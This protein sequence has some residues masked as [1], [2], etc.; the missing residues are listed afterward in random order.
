MASR[1]LKQLVE[2]G[3]EIVDAHARVD[4]PA[5]RSG[6]GK[7]RHI[8]HGVLSHAHDVTAFALCEQPCMAPCHGDSLLHGGRARL[9]RTCQ[10]RAGLGEY[11]GIALGGTRDHDGVATGFARDGHSIG[12]A[13]DVAVA[14]HRHIHRLLDARDDAPI[15]APAIQLLGIAAVHRDRGSSGIL[16]ADR[17]LRSRFAP[18]GPTAAE[19][20]GN[21]MFN[22]PANRC[23]D[24]SGQVRVAH[25]RAAVAFRDNLARGATHVDVDIGKILAHDLLDP[26][27]L[28]S[29]DIGLVAEQLHGHHVLPLRQIEQMTRFLIGIR[30][31]FSGNH[32]SI[33]QIGALLAA[34]R[35]KRHVRNARHRRKQQ[36]MAVEE[37]V[38]GTALHRRQDAHAGNER[39]HEQHDKG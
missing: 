28:G 24:G 2:H 16:H 18:H 33:R 37:I 34:Q 35:A 7:A 9:R 36:A 12:A 22:S 6:A 38:H 8:P 11:P 25:K 1:N 4:L 10:S 32:F 39:E 17:E 5:R 14:N 29:H 27:C 26:S 31:A 23:H 13:F 30:K 20:H 3:V 19:L 21:G 15:G